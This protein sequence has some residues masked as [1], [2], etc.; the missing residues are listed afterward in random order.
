MLMN[1]GVRKASGGRGKIFRVQVGGERLCAQRVEKTL[2]MRQ[3]ADKFNGRGI[4]LPLIVLAS[5]YVVARIG[6]H[7]DADCLLIDF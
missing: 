7:I 2:G 6:Y 3:V 5:K 1:P 4:S